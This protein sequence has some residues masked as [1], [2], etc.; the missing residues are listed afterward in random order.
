[1]F[2]R[3]QYESKKY[4]RGYDEG[5][6]H[7]KR[8]ARSTVKVRVSGPGIDSLPPVYATGVGA[9]FSIVFGMDEILSWLS[10]AVKADQ[11]PIEWVMRIEG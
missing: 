11:W 1:M 8:F 6:E 3:K 10:S 2:G 5:W 4:I 7:G 9:K